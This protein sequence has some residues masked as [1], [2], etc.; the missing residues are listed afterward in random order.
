MNAEPCFHCGLPVPAGSRFAAT[1]GGLERNLC[2]PG[3]VAAASLIEHS[4]LGNYYTYREQPSPR[5]DDAGSATAF[6]IYDEPEAQAAFVTTT[7]S[8][9]ATAQL[10]VDG[11][12]CAACTWLLEHLLGGIPGV[13][14]ISVNLAE[15][16][17]A[18]RFDPGRARLSELMRAIQ[19]V[20]YSPRPFTASAQSA[21]VQ[22]EGRALLRRLGIAGIVQM[23]IG[24]FA[25]ALYAGALDGIEDRYRDALRW[26]SLLMCIPVVLYSASPFFA[27]AWRGL[28]NRAP[29]MDLP[30]ALAIALAFV[31]S[32]HETLVR[33]SAV[34]FD[35]VSMFTFFL[36]LGRYLELRARSHAGTVGGNMLALLPA[37]AR[38]LLDD[39]RSEQV[40]VA[41]LARGDRVLVRAGEA[42][43]ADGL[44]SAGR[45]SVDESSFSG[46]SVPV[47]KSAGARVSAGTLLVEGSLTVEV[48]STGLATRLGNILA[49]V[50]R[51]LAEKPAGLQAA[52]RLATHFI[53]GV[54]ACAAL[55]GWYWSVHDAARVVEIVLAI[56]VIS[57][58]C[59]LSLATPVAFTV[60]T[61]A[62]RARGFLVTRGHALDA[63][64]AADTVFF[65]KT[66]TLGT[67]ELTLDEVRTAGTTTREECLRV[68]AAL[69]AHSP[70]PV[71]RAFDADD[72]GG[73]RAEDV[74]PYPGDGVEGR[75]EGYLWRIG[76]PAFAL[77]AGTAPPSDEKWIAL[78][79]DAE[80]VAWFRIGERCAPSAPAAIA[81]LRAAG[82]AIGLLSG[83]GPGPVQRLA[84]RLGI[85]DSE[86]ECS[87]ARKLERVRAAQAAGHVVMMVGDGVNDVPVLGGADVSIAVA[88][89]ADLTRTHAD[90][91]L[92][93]P[94]LARIPEA[95]ALALA[96]RA[97]VRQNL[98][99]SFVY[100]FLAIP[101]AAA[102]FVPPWL[103][104]IG[105]SASSVV[106]ILN[107]LRL[108][109]KP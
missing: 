26:T 32:I 15:R 10:A 75:I 72:S 56:L 105:M 90:C 79:R 34:Y 63:L 30:V 6:A 53:V 39:E 104:A 100:N 3:C 14:S 98:A 12:R 73:L 43:P 5:P 20:G 92:L 41:R 99:W 49:L 1:V 106:V 81:Q 9:S 70:H 36:L 18:I 60:A 91:I 55:G 7:D 108:Q 62:L 103:A 54:V 2:C 16:R 82:L 96:T 28:R 29:G 101:F 69:E 25:V 61:T 42:L 11:I 71:A 77:A 74:R 4:G 45:G 40:P 44:V 13:E 8:G 65:D 86:A 21:A 22:A 85:T 66:G 48:A 102:G 33:G 50:D 84:G 23:Q 67:A 89:A 57:C 24:M 80:A 107:A 88:G 64:A 68:A 51:A 27:G 35:S 19:S 94:D 59:A 87:P 93:S 38:R 37:A 95:R 31:A 52:D 83:D 78:S 109:R 76:K 17:A 58:P 46:E 47:G 97:V